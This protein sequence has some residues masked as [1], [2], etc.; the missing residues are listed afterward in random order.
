MKYSAYGFQKGRTPNNETRIFDGLGGCWGYLARSGVSDTLVI[1]EITYYTRHANFNGS[2]FNLLKPESLTHKAF[3]AQ[4]VD[5]I[6]EGYLE[7][8][9]L[10]DTGEGLVLKFKNLHDKLR[11]RTMWILFTLR[12]LIEFNPSSDFNGAVMVNACKTSLNL[13]EKILLSQLFYKANASRT[14]GQ[15]AWRLAFF[16][17]GGSAAWLRQM[18]LADLRGIL[19]GGKYFTGNEKSKMT[20][21]AG[22]GYYS[23]QDV[24]NTARVSVE[25]GLSR[26]DYSDVQG[27]VQGILIKLIA[28]DTR[29]GS[30]MEADKAFRKI[31]RFVKYY[32]KD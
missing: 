11:Q 30:S 6:N 1:N 19:R 8:E 14:L 16:E 22:G 26:D 21:G 12:S 18:T 5:A 27:H 31:V 13:R 10:D 3:L 17:S 24:Q 2:S 23:N 20:W 9:I 25:S 4:C 7:Y 29:N 28:T 15:Q 32:K